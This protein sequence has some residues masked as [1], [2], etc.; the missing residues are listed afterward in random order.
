[1]A[2]LAVLQVGS[3]ISAL[4]MLPAA[5]GQAPPVE[6]VAVTVLGQPH[7]GRMA[8]VVGLATMQIVPTF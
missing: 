5:A 8:T 7:G 2:A 3:Q 4:L 6:L 1:M